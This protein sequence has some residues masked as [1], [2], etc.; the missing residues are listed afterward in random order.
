LGLEAGV[1]IA[2]LAD[3][4]APVASL[5]SLHAAGTIDAGLLVRGVLLA[6]GVNTA[7]RCVVAALAGGG[8]YALRVGAG[9]ATSLA[10]ALAGYALFG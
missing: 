5:A 3:A 1:T 4:H 8:R 7:S 2:A 10:L 6:V 9:L